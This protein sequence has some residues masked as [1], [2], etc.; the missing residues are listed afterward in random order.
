M[1]AL[2]TGLWAYAVLFDI[3][4]YFG[5]ASFFGT[6]PSVHQ[7]SLNLLHQIARAPENWR[8][9]VRPDVGVNI[10]YAPIEKTEERQIMRD[11]PP[12]IKGYLRL[13]AYVGEGVFVDHQF[14]TTDVMIVTLIDRAPERY[15]QH[16]IHATGL[17]RKN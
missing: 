7:K 8:V 15:K 6:D 17:E 16:F 5:V 13:G 2:W 4:V 14:G 3:D 10:N 12:L 9:G 11:L 1:E